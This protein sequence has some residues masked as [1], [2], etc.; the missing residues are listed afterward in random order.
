MKPS[1]MTYNELKAALLAHYRLQPLVIAERFKFQK[2]NQKEGESVADYIMALRQLS[3]SCEFGQYLSDALRD[4]FVSG[5]NAVES[6]QRKLLSQKDL[7]FNQAC[8]TVSSMELASSNTLEIAD[9]KKG[10]VVNVKLDGKCM[11]MQLDTGAAV[12][13]M[14][15][16]SYRE[17]LSHLPLS[18]T[19]M[20]L[21]TYSGERIL[22]LGSVDVPVQYERQNV[23]LPLVIVKGE[24]PALL[25][26]NWLEKILLDWPNIFNVEK[27]EVA[28][29][30]A[31]KAVLRRHTEFFS[32]KPSTIK[33]FKA[34]IQVRPDATPIF[35]KARPVPYALRETVDKELDRLEKAGIV[36]KIE[37]SDWAAP[38]VVVPKSDMS[39][40][41]CGDYKVTINQNLE[42]ETYPLPNTEDL[43]AKLAGGTLF[44]K[45]DL[46][47]AYQQ[48]KL[49]QNSE[50]Y[51][52]INTHRGLY[53]YHRLSY[54][55]ASA[56]SIFQAV[57]DQI[58]QGLDFLDDILVTASTK[59]EH[60]R[61]L[62]E[63]L[64]RLERYGLRVKLSKCQF[65]QSSVE[66][67]G[68]RIDKEGLH[69][70]DEKKQPWS[71][72]AACDMAF[73]EAKQLLLGSTVLV[74]Y[75][76]NRPLKLECD[77]SPYGVGVVI[78]HI[79]DNGEECPIVFASRTLTE[80]EK[81]YAQIEQEALSIIYGPDLAKSVQEKQQEQKRQHDQGKRVLRS[82][83][84]EEPVRVRNFRG[85]QEKW[86]SAT[87]IERKGPIVQDA[88]EKQSS[89]EEEN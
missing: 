36:S 53:K 41:I 15:E 30:P 74:H 33:D 38:I 46:A 25:G 13:L 29:D 57:M 7:T 42:E 3:V 79:M 78:S 71:W 18:K 81:K 65:M 10:I 23:T 52:T 72:T 40:R 31:V 4:R 76:G 58:L 56:P 54:G 55:V 1:E 14:S 67:L 86:L 21:I 39:I 88:L 48:L 82:F 70:T 68:H 8:E 24:R 28:S 43:F 9:G 64:T 63:V 60:I 62:D 89:D 51:L 20:Q 66:Y 73:E 19:S 45:L 32:D 77:A 69:P 87:V 2:R 26:R 11:D 17:F 50:K 5:L 59:E 34:T 83:V 47:H 75:D 80:T 6:M 22:L 85:G 49:D 44:S 84:E 37:R 27:A 35:Q 61:K 16:L 12:S